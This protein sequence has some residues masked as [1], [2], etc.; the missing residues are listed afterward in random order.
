MKKEQQ[1]L[2]FICIG[3]L[4]YVYIF[5]KIVLAPV[6]KK[7]SETKR[8]ISEKQQKVTEA[9]IAKS[10]LPLLQSETKR[11]EL[12]IAELE[13]KVPKE[14]NLPE[15]IKIISKVS[16]YFGIK[17]QTLSYQSIDTSPP[18]Y[19]EIPFSISFT[20][21][22]HNLGQ[23]LAAIAQEKRIFAS[24]NLVL[25]YTGDK[26]NSVTGTFILYAYALK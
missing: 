17:L 19:N 16:Q 24:K 14:V 23:F 5:F 20:A 11:L 8:M 21:S 25:N 7:I 6:N 12:E 3:I 9:E 26:E 10:Q 1:I 22:Y 13:K 4:F 18:Q 15:L 2:I